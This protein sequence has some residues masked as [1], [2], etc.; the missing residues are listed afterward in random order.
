MAHRSSQR[1][2]GWAQI[3]PGGLICGDPAVSVLIRGLF[4]SAQRLTQPEAGF[5]QISS[6]G[7]SVQIPPFLCSS[8]GYFCEGAAARQCSLRFSR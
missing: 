2:A 8:V 6:F 3:F 1:E 5:A 4:E 7:L